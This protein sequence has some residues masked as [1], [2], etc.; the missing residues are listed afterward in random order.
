MRAFNFRTV[1]P[2]CWKT[3]RLKNAF[4]EFIELY[5]K[6]LV[7][8]WPTAMLWWRRML[9]VRVSLALYLSSN[10]NRQSL[11]VLA[12]SSRKMVWC[13]S[14]EPIGTS[15]LSCVTLN[16]VRRFVIGHGAE[17]KVHGDV[18][19]DVLHEPD[20]LFKKLP[21]E[22]EMLSCAISVILVTLTTFLNID[23]I[24]SNDF[25]RSV[26]SLTTVVSDD[27]IF[28]AFDLSA[29]DIN[30]FEWTKWFAIFSVF[31]VLLKLA[32]FIFFIIS[33][34]L[35][36]ALLSTEVAF[37]RLFSSKRLLNSWSSSLI[38]ESIIKRSDNFLISSA[39]LIRS[40][41]D[42]WFKT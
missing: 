5:S 26:R 12:A 7:M 15:R 9:H 13:E 21:N 20:V 31:V 40:R 42:V 23:G 2:F 32:F 30:D 8:P 24:S 4:M 19:P 36:C 41:L 17:P 1:V 22:S 18:E 28:D 6:L 39:K 27:V 35:I 33:D 25:N 16:L 3:F 38:D 11:V 14:G 29:S 10:C 37:G 34:R